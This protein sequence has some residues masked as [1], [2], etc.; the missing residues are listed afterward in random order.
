MKGRL[1]LKKLYAWFSCLFSFFFV[2]IQRCFIA[3]PDETK[4]CQVHYTLFLSHSKGFFETI[5]TLPNN[6]ILLV[7]TVSR[8]Y[9]F[10][11]FISIQFHLLTG[12][13]MK[14]DYCDSTLSWASLNLIQ[15]FPGQYLAW[16]SAVRDSSQIAS[17]LSWTAVRLL[18]RCPGQHSAIFILSLN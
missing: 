5:S 9:P 1:A 10:P 8:D 6:H 7:H 15:R 2:E 3:R 4:F 11:F 13:S 14:Y 17:A 16:F 12:Y 18:Q